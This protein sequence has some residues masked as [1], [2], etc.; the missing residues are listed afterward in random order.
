MIKEICKDKE[1]RNLSTRRLGG[2][3]KVSTTIE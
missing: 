2:K 3:I 1:G